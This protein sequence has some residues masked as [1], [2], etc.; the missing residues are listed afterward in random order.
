MFLVAFYLALR[1]RSGGVS[2]P[3]S[4]AL[5]DINSKKSIIVMLR[6]CLTASFSAVRDHPL[7]RRLELLIGRCCNDRRQPHVLS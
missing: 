3:R 7:P 6:A 4:G 2:R 5:V 1:E